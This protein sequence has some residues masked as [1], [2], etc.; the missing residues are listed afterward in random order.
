LD[1][2]NQYK[3]A[4]DGKEQL[5]RLGG[6]GNVRIDGLA[7]ALWR[8]AFYDYFAGNQSLRDLLADS[9]KIFGC[10]IKL[11]I[12]EI[13]TMITG[14][15]TAEQAYALRDKTV[16]AASLT[17]TF[18]S[19]MNPETLIAVGDSLREKR[20]TR[21]AESCRQVGNTSGTN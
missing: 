1:E 3:L 11:P 5:R 16:L 4:K 12:D 14:T 10:S 20:D 9:N 2:N 19:G 8:F 15:H 17:M 6:S 7:I 21:V 13:E 18:P